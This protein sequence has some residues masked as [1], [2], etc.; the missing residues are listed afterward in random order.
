M[1]TRRLRI[2]VVVS[3]AAALAYLWWTGRPGREPGLPERPRVAGETFVAAVTGVPRVVEATGVVASVREVV[4]AS[5]VVAAVTALNAREGAVVAAGDVLIELDDRELAA[6]VE[7]AEA[8]RRNAASRLER[9]R[10]V[11]AEGLVAPQTLEDAERAL[12]VAEAAREAA[13]ALLASATIRAPFDGVV[14]ERFIEVGDMATPGKPLLKVEDRRDFRLEVAVAG[15]DAGRIR[16]HQPAEVMIDALGPSRLA[17]KVAVIVPRAEAATQSVLVKVDLP[18]VP[19]LTSGLYGRARFTVGQDAL[20]TVPSSAISAVG[21]LDRVFVV[22]ADGVVHARL[23]RLG[24][25]FDD[26]VEVRTGLEPGERV[27]ADASRGVDGGL[28]AASEP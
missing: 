19:G 5:K 14:T 6:D 15:E 22:D 23:V 9:L 26:R 3:V 7:R 18:S 11:A 25:R 24:R 20:L 1:L 4:L 12:R 28:L 27:L 13:A 16:L 17:G 21:A 2:L 10:S 8:E